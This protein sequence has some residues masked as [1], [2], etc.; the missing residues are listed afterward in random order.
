V[1]F[2]RLDLAIGIAMNAEQIL[3]EIREANLSYL[4]LAQSLIRADREQALF[5]LGVSEETANLIGALTPAQMMKIASATRCCAASAWTTTWSG[6]CSPATARAPPTTASRLHA[7]ILMAGRHQEPRELSRPQRL[8][9]AGPA[10]RRTP[11]EHEENDHGAAKSIL[12]EAKQIERAVTLINLGA[13]LQVLESETDLSYERLLRLYKEV[14]GKQP[15]QGPAAVLDRLVHDLAAQH[16]RQP[17]PEHPRVPEQGGR[18]RRDR[19]RHQGL[20][21]VP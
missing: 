3:A 2:H 5:R 11:E 19:H 10:C 21:A 12:T 13:R 7:S 9:P 18:A 17:V 6:T 20:P 15:E 8:R 4:M 1:N 16:P 14:A